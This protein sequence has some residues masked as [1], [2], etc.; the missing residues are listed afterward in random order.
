[1]NRKSMLFIAF[2]SGFT[3]FCNAQATDPKPYG[4]IPTENQLRWQQ[5]E[6][7]G[8]IH[9]SLNTYTDQSWGFGNEDVK[10]FDPSHLD[11]RQWARTCKEAGMKGVIL[12]AKHHCGFCL[13]PSKYT[14]YSV[15]NA[16]WKNGKGDVVREMADACKQYGLKLGLYL[17]PWDRNRADY[18]KPEYITYFRNQLTELLTNYGPIFEIWF[19]GANGGSGYYGGANETRTIDRKTY[20]DWQNTYKLVRKLQPNIVIWNDNGDR[21]DLRWVG[22]EGG[23]VGETNWS[24]LNATGDVPYEMLHYGVEN[25]DTWVPGEVNTSIRPEWFYHP[26]EDQKVKTVP[27][28]MDVYYNSIGHNGTLLLNFPIMPNGLINDNDVAAAKGF[29]KAVKDAFTVNLAAN[30]SATASNTRGGNMRFSA[31]NATDNNPGSYW[32]TD[33]SVTTATLNINLPQPQRFNRFVVQEYIRLGQRVKAF[34]VDA[35]VDGAWKELAAGTTIGYKRIVRFATVKSNKVRLRITAAKACPL[36]AAT[37]LYYAPQIL[38]P[39]A[40]IRN[41]AGDVIITPADNESTVYYTS[42]G[43]V[44]TTASKKYSEPFPAEGTPVIQAIAYDPT[45]RQSSAATLEK[46]GIARKN[47]RVTGIDDEKAAAVLD[48]DPSTAW[49]QC[50]DVKMPVDLTIDLG[51]E[52][53]LTGFRYLPDQRAWNPGIIT[54]YEFYISADSQHWQQV[55]KG[56]FANIKNNPLWQ[57]VKFNAINARYIRLRALKNTDNSNE[58]GYAEIDVV[59]G[60]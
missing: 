7:Y 15:K 12:V 51:K 49:H 41:Q 11:C 21:A 25:G 8:F 14:D 24:L 37:G 42:D 45:T 35:L 52:K 6:Y 48:G 46:F 38:T 53:T 10:L 55:N 32:A 36:I 2:V 26:G 27:E 44:P 40:I 4:P 60:N 59:T 9:Y 29:A 22:T 33:D 19:D 1:M 5:M 54:A 57:T 16:P 43:T 34:T 39:P 58:A 18:G 20:Y 23:S 56:E 47:W 30:S 3:L 28:L 13:W 50:K 17:S 31:G